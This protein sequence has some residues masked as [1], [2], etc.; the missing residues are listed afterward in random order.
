MKVMF[1]AL[2]LLKNLQ[3]HTLL[4]PRLASLFRRGDKACATDIMLRGEYSPCKVHNPTLNQLGE[5]N[6]KKPDL[7][8]DLFY[9]LNC[10]I[11]YGF[12]IEENLLIRGIVDV[13]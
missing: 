10:H 8:A 6:S 12:N 7:L 2:P 3:T 4:H 9:I 13:I 1:L 5:L 11:T